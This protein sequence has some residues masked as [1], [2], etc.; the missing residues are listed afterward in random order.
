VK[1]NPEIPV[2]SF[3]DIAFLLIVFFIVATTLEKVNG[4]QTDIPSGQKSQS[5]PVKSPTIQLHDER[6]A[7]NE[8]AVTIDVLRVRLAALDL[9]AKKGDG[10]VVVVEATGKVPY[11]LYFDTMATV[12]AAGG[13]IA[14]VK[15][16][17]K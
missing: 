16:E 9:K 3:S 15:P 11:Q 5:Q 12:T 6:I 14:I 1:G 4:V 7:F 13:A 2:G 10:K 8:E 17:G